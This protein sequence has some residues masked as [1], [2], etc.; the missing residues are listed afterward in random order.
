MNVDDFIKENLSVSFHKSIRLKNYQAEIV[1]ILDAGL[2]VKHAHKF[3]TEN[4]PELK[5]IS[6]RNLY[7]FVSKIKKAKAGQAEPE[8]PIQ[9]TTEATEAPQVNLQEKFKE[10]LANVRSENSAEP[11][12]KNTGIQRR[13]K[14]VLK[15]EKVDE[16]QEHRKKMGL[17]NTIDDE[18]RTKPEEE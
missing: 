18:W 12:E 3:L 16:W 17:P 13:S 10:H 4:Y 7:L 6:L 15:P 14:S 8:K 11:I 2:T 5:N 1:K 9:P